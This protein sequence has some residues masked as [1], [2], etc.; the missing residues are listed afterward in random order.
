MTSRTEQMAVFYTPMRH[1]HPA[2]GQPDSHA[3]NTEVG[4]QT[5]GNGQCLRFIIPFYNKNDLI[6]QCFVCLAAVI[7][8]LSDGVCCVLQ[9]TVCRH[10]GLHQPGVSVHRT[11][12]GHDPERTV[13]PLRQARLGEHW[14]PEMSHD[15]KT[16]HNK[17][18]TNQ[19]HDNASGTHYPLCA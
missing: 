7:S 4:R 1:H 14:H 9:Y 3:A 15:K 6:T 8:L 13:C 16:I 12:A 2:M 11:G 19:S 5:V 18:K 10:R 17:R